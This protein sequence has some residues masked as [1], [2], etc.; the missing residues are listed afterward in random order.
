MRK[1]FIPDG[2]RWLLL[3]AICSGITAPQWL[4]A[5]GYGLTPLDTH[6]EK[7]VNIYFGSAK[8]TGGEYLQ[9]VTVVL[10]TSQAD[11]VAV[12]DVRGRFRL[13]LPLQIHPDDVKASCSRKGYTLTQVI[14]RAP[15]AGALTPVEVGCTLKQ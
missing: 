5:Q 4:A 10:Q 14:K 2:R 12:T 6:P 7:P 9:G 3:A 1:A 8:S 15:H 13:E 11:F